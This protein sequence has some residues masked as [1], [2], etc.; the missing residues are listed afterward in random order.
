[1]STTDEKFVRVRGRSVTGSRYRG[2]IRTDGSQTTS[3]RWTAEEVTR[4]MPCSVYEEC[5]ADKGLVLVLLDE[6]APVDAPAEASA[7]EAPAV[8]LSQLSE[9]AIFA[10]LERR[11]AARKAAEASEG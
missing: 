6:D 8:D 3:L 10:E 2:V 11:D 9:D 5:R 7:P 4:T 1:M